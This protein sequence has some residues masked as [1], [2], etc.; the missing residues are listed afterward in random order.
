MQ[1]ENSSSTILAITH[2][3]IS[4]AVEPVEDGFLTVRDHFNTYQSVID[5]DEI[6]GYFVS[7]F[8]PASVPTFRYIL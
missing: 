7:H 3:D 8:S 2:Y 4:K 1:E 5:I 6:T